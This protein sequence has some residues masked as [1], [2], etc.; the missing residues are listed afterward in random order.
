MVS[1]PKHYGKD[2]D[3]ILVWRAATREMNP[4]VPQSF[5]DVHMAEDPAR[6]SAEYLAEFRSDLEAFVQREVVENCTGGYFELAPAANTHYYGFVDA[7]GGSGGDSFA[8]A[9]SHREG[10]RI[11]VDCVR[12]RRPPFSPSAVIAE[13]VPL[14][15]SI[16]SAGLS[17]TDGVVVFRLSSFNNTTSS[18][19]LRQGEE[20][21]LRRS[22][23]N[24]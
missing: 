3:P 10:D 2:G 4:A 21:P 5:I 17:V 23:A 13:L 20:R 14:L 6:A 7:A 16:A 1:I 18:M 8:A 11:I 22:F 19:K 24:A 9:I 12:E 15:R